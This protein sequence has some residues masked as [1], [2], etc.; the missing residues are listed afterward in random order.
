[1]RGTLARCQHSVDVNTWLTIDSSCGMQ[2]LVMENQGYGVSNATL[3][4]M[5][6]AE[7]M[8]FMTHE[9]LIQV[10]PSISTGGR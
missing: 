9:D 3:D 6:E 8:K 5:T 10:A 7:K 4:I 2:D 1:M